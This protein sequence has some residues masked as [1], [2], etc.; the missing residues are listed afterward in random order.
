MNHV[1]A[2]FRIGLKKWANRFH[3]PED[4]FEKIRKK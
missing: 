1:D 3:P 2:A 4:T